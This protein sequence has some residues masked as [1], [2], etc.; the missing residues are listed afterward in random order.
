M[1]RAALKLG[2]LLLLSFF[3]CFFTLFL[4][5]AG[6]E[7][8]VAF[9]SRQNV[10]FEVHDKVIRLDMFLAALHIVV[11]VPAILVKGVFNHRGAENK[12]DLTFGLAW[13]QFLHHGF[14]YVIPLLNGNAIYPREFKRGASA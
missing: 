4:Y 12:A 14:F 11:I 1:E 8:V 3:Q 10:A 9:P 13:L 6:A 5:D 7:F 2:F